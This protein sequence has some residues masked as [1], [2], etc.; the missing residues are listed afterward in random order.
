MS[1]LHGLYGMPPHDLLLLP[2]TFLQFSPLLPGSHT[3]E[4]QQENSLDSFI[5][6]APPGTSERRYIL[7]LA[8]KAL[9]PGAPLNVLA[10]KDKGGQR[11]KQELETF[12]CHV[13][14]Q[15]KGHHRICFSQCPMSLLRIDEAIAGGALQFVPK[16][17]MWSQPGVFA[18]DRRDAG[19]RLLVEH[20]PLLGGQG[21][22]FGCGIGHL[23]ASLLISSQITVLH[24]IDIDRRAVNAAIK[25][26]TD[27]RAHAQWN[28]IRT[29]S[30]SGLD[31]VVM[32][33]PFHENGTEHRPLGLAFIAQAAK[34]LKR[35]GVLWLTANRH[36]PYEEALQ[37]LFTRS[38]LHAQ[39]DGY[40]IYESYS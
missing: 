7:A 23:A 18:W 8:L 36:L 15:S 17:N 9:K 35:G 32:N 29:I 5:L 6:A 40:K 33:P 4:E 37:R 14:Q 1:P 20:L 31:F 27:P 19:S 16:L 30:L 10:P 24:L 11:L 2:P 39:R 34:S 3:L 12:G 25:N 28:D 26:I 21:A 22:D 13:D 38:K